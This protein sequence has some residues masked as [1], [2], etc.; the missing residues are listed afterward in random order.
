MQFDWDTSGVNS[1]QLTAGLDVVLDFNAS[2]TVSL[3]CALSDSIF[4]VALPYIYV[5]IGG[6]PVVFVPKLDFELGVSASLEGS[7]TGSA[8][9]RADVTAGVVYDQA[10]GL[11]TVGSVT[12]TV[13]ADWTAGAK[14]AASLALTPSI[15]LLAYGLGGPKAGVTFGVGID[16]DPCRTPLWKATSS[17][18]SSI[19]LTVGIPW[20]GSVD[21]GKADAVLNQSLLAQG[22]T[23]IPDFPGC[24]PPP[25]PLVSVD[26]HFV[27]QQVTVI[28]S[29]D[30]TD[31]ATNVSDYEN[32]LLE[33]YRGVQWVGPRFGDPP[34]LSVSNATFDEDGALV[35]GSPDPVITQPYDGPIPGLSQ[36]S[37]TATSPGASASGSASASLSHGTTG[38]SWDMVASLRASAVEDEDDDTDI[39]GFTTHYFASAYAEAE[40]VLEF[41]LATPANMTFSPSCPPEGFSLTLTKFNVGSLLDD[42]G[43]IPPG[44]LTPGIMTSVSLRRLG[45]PLHRGMRRSR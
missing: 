22:G 5:V 6:L 44:P 3:S 10:S 39:G 2:A 7:I 17:I 18:T 9:Y 24:T 41:T 34:T 25:V 26:R 16:A 31:N 33:S 11:S 28:A 4:S 1:A 36:T 12:P 42:S 8:Q 13:T 38:P 43:C 19:A 15:S 32:D 21:L 14:A 30:V 27:G 37:Q 40:V 20:L 45:L 35:S 23:P 29:R